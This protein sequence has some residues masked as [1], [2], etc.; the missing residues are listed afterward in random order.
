MAS[1][2][3]KG[4]VWYVR[5]RD[6]SGRQREVKAGP[7]KSVAQSIACDLESKVRRIKAGVLDPREADCLDAERIPITQHVA[8][9]VRNREDKGFCPDHLENVRKRLGWFLEETKIARLSQL[10]PSLADSALKALRD[11]GR[12]DQ[13]VQ[14]YATCWKSFSKWAWKNRRTRTDML[15]DLELPKVV[16]TSKRSALSP[17]Q[18]T[19]LVA[20]TRT[21]KSR[22]RMTGE[23]RAWLYTL[24]MVTGLRRGE[25]QSLTPE[26]FFLDGSPA[27]VS[28]PGRDTKNSDDAIQPLPA[29]VVPALRSWLALKPVGRSLWPPERNTA[30]MVRTDLKA[31]GIA[32]EAFDFHCLRHSYVSAIVQCGGSVKDS[33]ELA[34]HH[35]ADLTFNRYAH[36]RLADL[37]QV[38]DRLPSLWEDSSHAL[39]TSGVSMGQNGTT[40]ET[41]KP[42][43]ERS[44]VDPSRHE[45]RFSPPIR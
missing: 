28:L 1:L 37:S 39:P 34:R 2:R 45:D 5:V 6:E 16:T 12:S 44:Q 42:C 19:R 38:V 10:R 20:S 40:L 27:V 29:H 8:D 33:M 23:D 14:H 15:A 25:L 24:A 18:A 3:K 17:E 26:S 13:T 35:D 36:T 41:M 9:Y 30:L 11:A 7:D 21:G 22:C 31:A 43:P 4:K 32:P